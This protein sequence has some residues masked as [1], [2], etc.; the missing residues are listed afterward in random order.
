MCTDV[1]IRKLTPGD[2]PQML[3][4]AAQNELYFKYAPPS[5][6][7]E[8]MADGLLALP[9]KTQQSDKFYLGF[10]KNAKLIAMLD[11]VLNYPSEKTA[12]IGLFMICKSM[13]S[14]GVGS[15]IISQ[16]SDFL[17]NE[18]FKKLRLAYSQQNGA[19][20]NFWLKNLF[21]HTGEVKQLE[22]F[23]AV[24]MERELN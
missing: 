16:L 12:F 21:V 15:E 19:A 11:L 17:K 22:H 18:Q 1:E 9:P 14:Q 24:L 4:L 5:P 20:K 8:S 7:A 23:V 13:Q 6:T 3:C 2:V 10:F